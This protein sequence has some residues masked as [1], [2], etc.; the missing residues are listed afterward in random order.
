MS[1]PDTEAPSTALSWVTGLREMPLAHG[2]RLGL[3]ALATAAIL[4]LVDDLTERAIEMRMAEDLN[5][6]LA[7][8]IPAERHDN[9][10]AKG[11]LLIDDALEGAVT[12]YR[13]TRDGAVTGVAFE[14]AT[15]GYSGTIRTLVGLAPAGRVLGARVLAHTETPGLGDKIEVAKSD[16]ILG[17]NGLSLGNPRDEGWRVKRDGGKFD[18]FS[19]ATITPRS[20][21]GGVHRAL[22][23]FDRHRGTLLSRTQPETE[24]SC[25]WMTTA[26]RPATGS[27]TTTSFSGSYWHSARFWQ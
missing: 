3:F 26:P 8:V 4:A 15:P 11:H 2:I 9:D 22:K 25:C 27:G 13:A 20:V 6:S 17:F 10:L 23:F 16:W 14:I 1:A 7:Q 18:Q 21:V 12:V 5:A 19:G 24:A